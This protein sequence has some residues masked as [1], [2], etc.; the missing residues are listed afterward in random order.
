MILYPG[1]ALVVQGAASL[2]AGQYAQSGVLTIS[3]H[4]LVFEVGGV[5]PFTAIDVTLDR[6]WNVHVGADPGGLLRPKQEF[7]TVESSHGR[8]LF[9]VIGASQWASMLVRA[10]SA[11]PTPPPPPPPAHPPVSGSG[12]PVIINLP[13][14]P[15]PKI[16]LHCRYCGALYDSTGGRCD[17]CGGRP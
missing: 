13:A 9:T 5:S 10:K 11:A 16:M 7:L 8:W 1:E 2:G 15:A 4:R 17:K 6:V 12:S 14:T 3:T